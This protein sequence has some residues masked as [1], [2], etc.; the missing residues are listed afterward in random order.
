[1]GGNP[2]S[3]NKLPTLINKIHSLNMKFVP[4]ID[5]GISYRPNQNY[6]AF[7]NGMKEDIFMKV[8]GEVFIGKVWPNEAAYPDFTHPNSTAWWGSE[9]DTFHSKIAFD[10]I[11][12][13]MNEA[14]N[15]C[16]GDCFKGQQ[17]A[18]PVANKLMYTPTGEDIETK[19][20]SLDVKHYNNMTQLD[21]HSFFGASQVAASNA[22]FTKNNKR[23]MVISRSSF[24]GMGKYGS[25][26]L[27]DNHAA[28]DDMEISVL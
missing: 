4:I 12:Q 25:A 22:W 13:D 8:N 5:A 16:N 26:W 28:V 19:S 3:F 14:S 1:M 9:L 11:W 6:K 2:G 24:A 27:G 7:D 17:A 20:I 18:S 23:T 10:G 15:F 21:A